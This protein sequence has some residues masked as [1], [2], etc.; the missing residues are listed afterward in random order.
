V[1]G[2]ALL[3]LG[4]NHLS[5]VGRRAEDTHHFRYIL[6]LLEHIDGIET[7]GQK[8]DEGITQSLHPGNM[9]VKNKARDNTQKRRHHEPFPQRHADVRAPEPTLVSRCLHY[10]CS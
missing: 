3:G 1:A 8:Q 2:P 7:F 4:D 10:A 5:R 9:L 6:H